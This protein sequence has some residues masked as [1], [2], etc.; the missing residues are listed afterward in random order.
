MALLQ[1][2]LSLK[3][4]Q[5]QILTPGLMQMVSVLALNKLE[6][7]EMINAEIVE[8]PVLEEIEE[9]V[10]LLDELAGREADRERPA[11]EIVAVAETPREERDPFDEIDFGCYFQDYLDPGFR[12]PNC[13]ELTDK[14]SFENFLSQPNTL[15]DHLVW[16]LGSLSIG[17]RL[18]EA[19]EYI[20]GNLSE[21]G[22]LMATDEELLDG[23]LREAVRGDGSDG[24]A[25]GR[26]LAEALHL[27]QGFDPCGV[28][29]RDLRECLSAQLDQQEREFLL[30]FA[31]PRRDGRHRNGAG[32]GVAGDDQR[33]KWGVH[34]SAPPRAAH[35]E[36]HAAAEG[37][38]HHVAHQA[39]TGNH[40]SNHEAVSGG[41]QLEAVPLVAVAAVASAEVAL[42]DQ[43]SAAMP[44]AATD[45]PDELAADEVSRHWAAE[46]AATA[47]ITA[48]PGVAAKLEIFH[49]A[50]RIVQEYLS[51]LLKRDLSEISRALG[52]PAEVTHHAVDLIRSLDPRPG[53]RFSHPDAR[54][55]EPDVTFVK[56]GD[57]FVVVMNEED[58]PT[59]RLNQGY[60]KL[61]TQGDTERDVKEY[62]KERYR[63]ALQLMRNIEQR[64]STILRTCEAIIRRQPEF[65]EHGVEA[66]KPMMIKDVA[67]EIGVHP[68]TVSRAVSNKYV[69][70]PQGVYELRF[71]FSEGVNGPEGASTPLLLL[72]RKVK[73]LIDEENPSKPLTDDLIASMLQVQGIQV[74]R[75]TVAKYREDMRIPSTHQR[76]VR[77]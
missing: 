62:V 6:L 46:L 22:Y 15:T 44:A 2:K 8:N 39:H 71:F 73:K 65:L 77:G 50:R 61:L 54:L 74:T 64:K 37:S 7:K 72:K 23:Y 59:L 43:S 57:E 10:P 76:R 14:P 42:S 56:R 47:A 27:V 32:F 53:Q 3:V 75:R 18:R 35:P 51:L 16:Q 1:P 13:F 25:A 55:I 49:S 67:E 60:R 30:M 34:T 28:A 45:L 11:E 52:K 21:D 70:T 26:L 58:L 36:G 9:S 29:T 48:N 19:A 38:A 66:L 20:I 5:R 40:S 24:E 68:S 17:P 12:T 33:E 63:S 31:D 41:R 69:H 4:S